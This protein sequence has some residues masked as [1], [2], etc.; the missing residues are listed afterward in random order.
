M[1]SEKEFIPY[2][3]E[4]IPYQV[5]VKRLL[6]GFLSAKGKRYR[7]SCQGEEMETGTAKLSAGL[8]AYCAVVSFRNCCRKPGA[9]Y[10]TAH[11]NRCLQRL[12]RRRCG[13]SRNRVPLVRALCWLRTWATYPSKLPSAS[14]V[15]AN[16]QKGFQSRW[17]GMRSAATPYCCR[18]ECSNTFFCLSCGFPTT[19]Y[20]TT[21]CR[22]YCANSSLRFRSISS[23]AFPE[24]RRCAFW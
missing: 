21:V 10:D 2:K 9:C 16:R 6:A 23:L 5:C 22:P 8:R 11:A 20:E 18:Q 14:E 1:Q 12:T 13:S 24:R 4:F 19:Y 3:K 17:Y 15:Q 7:W